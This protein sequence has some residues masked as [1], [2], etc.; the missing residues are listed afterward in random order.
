MSL[1]VTARLLKALPVPT[2]PPIA[3]LAWAPAAVIVRA[4]GV[5]T[6]SLL[7]VDAKVMTALASLAVKVVSA[8]RV[9]ASPKVCAPLVRTLPPWRTVLPPELVIRLVSSCP[10][11]E[12]PT[13]PTSVELPLSMRLSERAVPSDMTVPPKVM[14]APVKVV[15]APRVMGPV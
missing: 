1:A 7:T 8:P 13:A 4:R 5:K 14:P 6:A 10:E 11:A 2:A 15:L 12:P 9:S 3:T